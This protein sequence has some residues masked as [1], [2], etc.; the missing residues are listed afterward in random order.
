MNADQLVHVNMTFL[1]LLCLQIRFE[2]F[3]CLRDKDTVT[4]GP[5][6]YPEFS[7]LSALLG[8]I[9]RNYSLGVTGLPLTQIFNRLHGET[10]GSIQ[11]ALRSLISSALCAQ[12]N[13]F[14][15]FMLEKGNKRTA[16]HNQIKYW[17]R[18]RTLDR[19]KYRY[20]HRNSLM[21]VSCQWWVK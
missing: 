15:D 2:V 1:A 20:R 19:R 12:L 7:S 4:I 14:F 13:C 21:T 11:S 10:N 17:C 5:F 9:T 16:S 18:R 8:I 6:S 3:V